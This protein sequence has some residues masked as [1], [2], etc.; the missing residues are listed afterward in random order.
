MRSPANR[1]AHVERP[2]QRVTIHWKKIS[3]APS[4]HDQTVRTSAH[5]E[6]ETNV[7]ESVGKD[8]RLHRSGSETLRAPG[9]I[10]A[11]GNKGA[12]GE[13]AGQH[14]RLDSDHDLWREGGEP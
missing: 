10:V 14:S 4:P 2:E 1:L 8:G 6:I 9:Q 11:H 3:T 13:E 7:Q 12:N 5:H